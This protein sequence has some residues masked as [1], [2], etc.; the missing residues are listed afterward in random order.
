MADAAILWIA[1]LGIVTL[2]MLFCVLY[3]LRQVTVLRETMRGLTQQLQ[4]AKDEHK[5]ITQD[6]EKKFLEQEVAKREQASK[7]MTHRIQMLE[8]EIHK[9][10]N[11][12][13]DLEKLA[14]AVHAGESSA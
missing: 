3:A 4:G 6:L 9:H 2:I 8:G 5:T 13:K 14:H 12:V 7:E 1:A 11:K 10:D